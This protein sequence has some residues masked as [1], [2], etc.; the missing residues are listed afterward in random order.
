MTLTLTIVEFISIFLGLI[1]LFLLFKLAE[2]N[3]SYRISKPFAWEQAVKAGKVSTQ[4]KRLERFYRDKVRFYTIWIQIERLKREQ[5]AGVFAELG[6]YKGETAKIIH[7]ADPDRQFYLLDTF[8]GFDHR[9]LAGENENKP[10]QLIDFSDTS[11]AS[12]LNYIGDNANITLLKGRFPESAESLPEQ[13]YALVHLDADLYNPTF[14]GLKYFYSRLSPGG[15]ILIH[16][17]NHNWEG[18]TRAVNDF[19]K[20]IPEKPMEIADWQGSVMIVKGVSH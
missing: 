19:C 17:Y 20:T 3:W 11:E 1:F 13:R 10:P 4:L 7:A 15:V 9:D 2:T 8:E 12:V 5:V 14:E 18:V 6:V 16:D